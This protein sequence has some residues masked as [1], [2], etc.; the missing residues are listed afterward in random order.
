M[1]NTT[2][3]LTLLIALAFTG[4][5]GSA[6]AANT[7]GA[8]TF[9][10]TTQN[11]NGSYD[12]NNIAVVWVVDSNGN[13]VKTLCRHANARIQYLYKWIASRGTYTTV[14]GV[15]SATL[16]SQ[17][18]T[19]AVTWDCRGTN[20]QV[21]ADGLYYF[22]AEYTSSNAQGP[23]LSNDC[24][25]VKGTASVATN[26]PDVSASP[27]QFTG[28][29]LAYTPAADIRV[30]ALSPSIGFINSNVTV[31]VAISNLTLNAAT[32]GVAVSNVTSGTLIGT[33]SVTALGGSAATNLSFNWSTAGLTAGAYSVRAVASGLVNETVLSNNTL[34][35]VINLS[36]TNA[37]DIAVTALSPSIGIL[38]ALVPVS[39]TVTN[40]MSEATGP[41]TVSLT[42]LTGGTLASYSNSWRVAASNND[43]EEN[44]STHA[45]GLTS[46]DLEL[47]FDTTNQI[48][49]IRFANVGIPTNA[50]LS[51]ANIQ[52]SGRAGDL[53][54][55]NPISLTI[56][57]QAANNADAFTTTASSIS[58]RPE[59]AAAVAWSPANWVDGETGANAKT[60]DLKTVVQEIVSR[61]GWSSGNAVV[62]K[63]TGSGGRR[64]WSY[65]GNASAA[66]LLT[67]QW[68]IASPLIATQYVANVAAGASTNV[69]LLWN[70]EGMT[71][72]V[73]QVQAF[74]GPLASETHTSD[75]TLTSGITL[76]PPIHN[77][78]VQAV[79]IAPLVPPNV[80]TNIVVTLTNAGDFAE[81]FTHTLRDITAAP[82]T[83]GSTAVN[84]L[85]ANTRTNL[86]YAWNTATN[87]GF[88]LGVHT[89]QAGVTVVPG[90]T[91]IADNT[92]EFQVI[93]ST[94]LITNTLVAKNGIW[95]FLDKGLDISAAP[96]Q[97]ETYYDGFWEEGASPLGYG[98]PNIATSIGFGG[99]SS[100]RYVTTYLRREFTL[101][102]PPTSLAGSVMRTHGAVIYLNGTEIARQNMPT[103]PAGYGTFASNT[104]S[105]AAATNFFSFVVPPEAIQTGRNLL[106]AELHLAAVTNTTTGFSLELTSVNPY[107]PP[108]PS[109][110]ATAMQP[111]GSVQS[112]DALGVFIELFNNGNT[113]TSCL[114][115][116]KDATTGA[117]L[118]SQTV[119]TLA[120]GEGTLIRLTWPTFGATTGGRTLQAV[121]VINGVTNLAGA[122]TSPATVDALNFTAK[123]VNA[124]GS[125][126]G[127]CSAV[128]VAGNIL[129]LGCGA[130]LEAWDATIP[131]APVRVGSLRLPGLIEDLAASN[132]WVYAATGVAGVQIVDA[133]TATQ[134]VHR[135][136]FD[137]SGFAR[138]LA[139]D[140]NLLYIADSVAGI[141]VLNMSAPA[142]PTLAGAY[143]TT[144]PAQTVTPIPP[145]LLALDLQRGL[146]ILHAANPAAMTVTG[147]VRQVTAGIALT[148]VSGAAL[149]ADANGGLFRIN[150][151]VPASPTLATNTLLSAAGRSLATSGSALYVAA[152]SAGLVTLDAITLALQSTTAVGDEA[153]DVAVAG[154]TLY[155]A[156]GFAGCR[157]FNIASPFSPQPL[158]TLVTGAR[159]VDAAASGSTLFVAADEGG[160]QIHSLE[161]LALPSLL[162]T[163]SSTSNSRC[164]A[165]S[166][167]LACVGDGL[168]G[169][170]IFNIAN[171]ASP[172][173]VGSY[174][175]AGLSHIRR[176]ALSG[177]LAVLTDGRVLQLLSIANPAAPALLATVTNAPGSFV[178]DLAAVGNQAYAA[179]GR[180][181]LRIYGLDN[182]LN[183]DNAVA[184]PGPATGVTSVSNLLHVSCGPYG[185]VTLSIAANPVSPVLVKANAAGMAFGAAS[186]GPL[187]Y[188]TDGARAGQALNVSAPL[189]PVA[190]TNFPGLTQALRVRAASGLILTAEDEAGLAILNASPGDINLSGIPDAWE[191]QIVSASLATNGPIRSV[192]DVDPQAIGP[193]GYPYYQSY[194]AGLSPIDPNSVLAIS[195]ANSVPADNGK[196]VVQW[197]SVPGIKYVVHKST[198]LTEIAAGFVPVSPILTATSSL[199]SY[200]NTVSSANAY[201]MVITTP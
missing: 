148:A 183:L 69:V 141:R 199:T 176:I 156:A 52:F 198:N 39:V 10:T 192:L 7:D 81:S 103:G 82:L 105:G 87:A 158:A 185:W 201:F 164:V 48:V 62:F 38:D 127:R 129:F 34:T 166:H 63:I 83:I 67:V 163:V 137:T 46:T 150:T 160:F 26:Y 122:T 68:K 123:Q 64:A 111:E 16:S 147:S 121:T 74:A 84:N 152:G 89:L 44:I 130:T 195:A 136:T 15:T 170:K 92:N 186:A 22:R 45:V 110:A 30:A 191:Q 133:A 49:G 131:A 95:K 96:W 125:V 77:V 23:Y 2:L 151:A 36:S 72:G 168:Y 146:Q 33:Q 99:V 32:F 75:N 88:K 47:V 104:V 128:A 4:L 27:G 112:G 116:L 86:T 71:G 193:N 108:L 200:T 154:N 190:V 55:L 159:P 114:V 11:Y 54:N 56:K 21:V 196:F 20:G 142:S 65:D 78:A 153:Y 6:D 107:I 98:L 19:H 177:S 31:Q 115:L 106:A 113:A 181:G 197:M 165:V 117:V 172:T 41:F 53:L 8:V 171:A 140:G 162:A 188:L 174:P 61:P 139:L 167:P 70:T 126:G 109:V 17:P 1:K 101:D 12:P 97:Q 90:E 179:C 73:Y 9:S 85:P 66:P 175:A 120:P 149:A 144:G 118:A 91:G 51:S 13:F 173:L 182:N 194:L 135:A 59:T 29:S 80:N 24:A 43:A 178:F 184:T 3:V 145:R 132:G 124:V 57:G 25:F 28:L 169:L 42:N 14:D 50:T 189:T 93:V 79:V 119:D 94:G 161:N 58:S 180:A 155:V 143:H 138:R 5:P 40:F 35:G 76:R 102:F 60:P 37:G 134:L 100:N 187:V 18:Q 157:S